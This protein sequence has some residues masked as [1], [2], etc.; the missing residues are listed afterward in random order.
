MSETNFDIMLWRPIQD[1]KAYNH[2]IPHFTCNRTGTGKGD[3]DFSI[4]E[5][6]AMV[7]EYHPQM[8]KIANVLAKSSLIENC[9]TI[10]DFVYGHFQYKADGDDQL[11]RSPA[12][13][14]HDRYIGIDCKSY[15]ILA[16]CLLTEMN[17]IHYIRKIKQPG[18]APTEWTH[19]YVVVPKDQTK[20][21]LQNGYYCI[22]G[23]LEEDTEPNFIEKSDLKMSLQH[24]RLNGVADTALSVLDSV[25]GGG[26]V[27]SMIVKKIDWKSI[28]NLLKTPLNCWGGT[29]YNSNWVK[30]D[31]DSIGT[32]LI[33]ILNEMK[34]ALIANNMVLFSE[35]VNQYIGMS[36]I[37]SLDVE[38]KRRERSWNS[39]SSAGFTS[40]A[41]ACNYYHTT[42][43]AALDAWLNAGFKSVDSGTKT[44]TGQMLIAKGVMSY[45]SYVSPLPSV[46]IPYEIFSKRNDVD[47]LDFDVTAYVMTLVK[48]PSGLNGDKFLADLKILYPKVVQ[49]VLNS[50][51]GSGS[52][53][54]TS[55]GTG[56]TSNYIPSVEPNKAGLGALGWILLL[57][58]GGFVVSKMSGKK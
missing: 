37:A 14:W 2:L 39:C 41:E 9:E 53:P 30:S 49:V 46:T 26:G 32:Y 4:T 31:I 56:T 7:L 36:A 52:N 35:K 11:L 34:A 16:S 17:I 24:Y 20:G 29:A 45:A 21:D 55:T 13:S 51:S 44:Y 50:G 1:G 22:D 42:I 25:S 57:C 48:D 10:K 47:I 43:T 54:G 8:G 3:T 19:V 27:V 33:G 5:M 18:Y 6:E 40:T 12:C 38:A 15:S 58:G 23:T 28:L